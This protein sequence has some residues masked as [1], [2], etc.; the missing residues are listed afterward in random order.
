MKLKYLTTD[1][2]FED[3]LWKTP[4][5]HDTNAESD[6]VA[7]T[8]EDPSRTQQQF[9]E[10]T[11]I[12]WILATYA[13]RE[14]TPPLALPEHFA[15]LSEGR[16][17]YLEMQERQAEARASFYVLPP[18]IRADHLNNPALWADQVVQATDRGDWRKLQEL[19][20]DAKEPL[21]PAPTPS[22]DTPAPDPEKEAP[23]ASKTPPKGAKD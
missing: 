22:G 1:G 2:V 11:D 23:G 19:G 14:E 7:L 16:M 3:L 10:S 9:K 12:N 17:T 21:Q 15:D 13:Q 8:C 18:Q 20:L 4:Y 5:N 6:R